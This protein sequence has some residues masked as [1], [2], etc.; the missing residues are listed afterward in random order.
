M[1]LLQEDPDDG[2]ALGNVACHL[3]DSIFSGWLVGCYEL[4]QPYMPGLLDR[5]DLA[6]SRQDDFGSDFDLHMARL[7]KYRSLGA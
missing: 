3:M 6:I 5:I 4:V 1:L 7:H 2:V